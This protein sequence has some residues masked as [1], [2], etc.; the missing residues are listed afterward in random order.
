MVLTCVTPALS[1]TSAEEIPGLSKTTAEQLA[2]K[3]G[4]LAQFGADEVFKLLEKNFAR[5]QE[6]RALTDP[7]RD[8][9]PLTRAKKFTMLLKSMYDDYA[10]IAAIRDQIE[11]GLAHKV[12]AINDLRQNF[13]TTLQERQGQQSQL[14]RELELAA[15]VQEPQRRNILQRSLQIRLTLLEQE[16][17]QWHIFQ[18]VQDQIAQRA[19]EMKEV[20]GLFLFTIEQNAL[21][22]ERA[23]SVAHTTLV[24]QEV[25]STL[26]HDL[27]QI[28]RFTAE[29]VQSWYE[30][31]STIRS[32]LNHYLTDEQLQKMFGTASAG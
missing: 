11:R 27:A 31:E 6:L 21:V 29:M 8:M 12:Q 2:Q 17:R 19:K 20:I 28:N 4:E 16:L 1:L 7:H 30:L 23:Y 26:Y 3:V 5:L 22:Y 13:Q 9:E 14:T 24:V 32:L 15:K 10:A 25:L 18:N